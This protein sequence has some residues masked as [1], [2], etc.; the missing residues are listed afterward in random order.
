[1]GEGKQQINKKCNKYVREMAAGDSAMQSGD[2][3]S[4]ENQGSGEAAAG[5]WASDRCS[6]N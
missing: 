2:E 5:Q 3:Q 6:E 4:R 1:M